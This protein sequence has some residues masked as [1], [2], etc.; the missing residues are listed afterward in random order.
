MTDDAPVKIK[1]PPV[2]FSQTQEIIQ[3]L[4]GLLDGVLITY[5]NSPSGSVCDNDVVAVHQMLER[6]GRVARLSLFIKSE[7]A[8]ARPR[9]GSS[10]CCASTPGRSSR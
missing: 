6:I 10:T 4:A 3:R 7:G 5:W 1:Q 2:L 8:T 9:S